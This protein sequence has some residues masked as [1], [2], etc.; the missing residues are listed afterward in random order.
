[1]MK[2]KQLILTLIYGQISNEKYVP[3]YLIILLETFDTFFFV[4]FE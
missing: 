2:K 4:V 3:K 1:M